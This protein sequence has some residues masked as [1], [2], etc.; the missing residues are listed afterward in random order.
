MLRAEES[1][2]S[3]TVEGTCQELW[4]ILLAYNLIRLEM[5]KVAEEAE[6]PAV[7]VSFAH[8]LRHLILEWTA[9]GHASPGTLPGRLRKL[10]EDLQAWVLPARR[11]KRSYPRAVKVKMSRFAKKPSGGAK[12]RRR[13][14][15]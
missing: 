4:G 7:Q 6:V 5:T 14:S 12:S 13:T 2:R 11:P 3:K 8:A 10:R 1:L 9:Y 15:K